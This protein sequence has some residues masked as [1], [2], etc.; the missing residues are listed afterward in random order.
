MIPTDNL[1]KIIIKYLTYHHQT[2]NIQ[3]TIS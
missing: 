3:Q 2:N 1:R